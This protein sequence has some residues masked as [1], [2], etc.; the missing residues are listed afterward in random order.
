MVFLCLL[1]INLNKAIFLDRDGVL[2]ENRSDYVK[3]IHEL[4]ILDIGSSIKKLKDNNFLIIVITNQSAINRGLTTYE[5]VNQIHFSIQEYLKKYNVQIDAFYYCPHHPDD[6]C[7]CRKPQPGLILQAAK[8]FN[9][10]L[11]SSWMVGDMDTDIQAAIN[12]GCM[13]MKIEKNIDLNNIVESI[14]NSL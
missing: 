10:D 1:T 12:A 14:L 11:I 8:D 6:H 3:T 7:S 13:H 5:N 4:K 2:N 9:I